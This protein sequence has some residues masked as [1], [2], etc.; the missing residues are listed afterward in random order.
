M[1]VTQSDVLIIGS[2]VAGLMAADFLRTKLNVTI[3]TKS[4]FQQSN[5]Y[6]AQGGI[7]ASIDPNDH[8][9]DH[10]LDTI[11]A[12]CFHNEA[13]L[14][15]LLVQEA[16]D[17]IERLVS[18]GVPFD[19]TA[20]G[21]LSLGRE[22]G[23]RY[24]RIIHAGG[25][26]TGA[27]IV[28]TLYDR[29]RKSI[30]IEEHE[31]AGDLI[32]Q[33]GKC[34]G[35][36]TKNKDDNI[37]FYYAKHIILAT[38]GMAGLYEVTSNDETITGDGIAMAYRAGAALSDLEFVQFHPTMLYSQGKA[39]GLVSEAV[40]GEGARLVTED[41]T[42]IMEGRH[43]LEDLAPRDIVARAI[44]KKMEEGLPVYLDITAV[45][46]FATRFPSITK[47]CEKANIPI[48][49]GRIPIKPGAH[50]SMGGVITDEWGE[51]SIPHLYAI[52]EVARTG[53][54]GANRL[55][56]NSLLE[57]MVF[58][59]QTATHILSADCDMPQPDYPIPST[60]SPLILPDKQAIKK[61]MGEKAGIVRHP[62]ELKEAISWFESFDFSKCNM[63][64]STYDLEVINMLTVGW[65]TATSA[66]MRTESRGGHYRSDYPV[67][68]D[69]EWLR[70]QLIRK[71]VND[72]YVTSEKE[73]A[74]VLS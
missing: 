37:H 33:D 48:K 74:R 26:Q 3:I 14:T 1:N 12:G 39:H 50:F 70:R 44:F 34:I 56:S 7:S 47:L 30:R 54:H 62:V 51:T 10:F 38:G 63:F 64:C 42:P 29:L 24:P 36:W 55:A 13:T 41:G 20:S 59:K 49:N 71:K 68:N 11:T 8:W 46:N 2:G 35:V 40:R 66:L 43:P 53:V 72:E 16:P 73:I 5:S 17:I 52:G 15:E 27:F 32:I 9:T 57:G 31:F 22:G 18:I 69:Q 45:K 60:Y 28:K 21:G 67:P 25:D 23:H 19:K 6:Y 58:A 61:T 65:L 4:T